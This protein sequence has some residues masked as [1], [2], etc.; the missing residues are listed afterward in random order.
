VR[1]LGSIETDVDALLIDGE[2]R[3]RLQPEFDALQRRYKDQDATLAALNRQL[4]EIIE[5]HHDRGREFLTVFLPRG[6]Q[7]QPTVKY[8]DT[9]W[10]EPPT[11]VK[12]CKSFLQQSSSTPRRLAV[13][14]GDS[15]GRLFTSP[16]L[17]FLLS[18]SHLRLL[19]FS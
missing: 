2:L 17:A 6:R 9:R 15:L 11:L 16:W 7:A 19:H 10:R 18:P 4:A 12:M 1:S 13:K 3:S 5:E 14:V 8:Q